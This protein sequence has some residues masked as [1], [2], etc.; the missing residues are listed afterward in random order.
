MLAAFRAPFPLWPGGRFGL[1][2]QGAGRVFEVRRMLDISLEARNFARRRHP[3]GGRCSKDPQ[4][5]RELL[6]REL[7]HVA[8]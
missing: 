4:E 6:L 8:T 1:A 7:G 2:R 5:R 3:V